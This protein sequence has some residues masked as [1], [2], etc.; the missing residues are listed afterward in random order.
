MPVGADTGNLVPFSY[1]KSGA[2][3]KVLGSYY[4]KELVLTLPGNMKSDN[5]KWLAVWCRQYSVNFGHVEFP[6]TKPDQKG[7]QGMSLS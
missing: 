7:N 1:T 3:E 2:N 6:N 4:Q 5:V